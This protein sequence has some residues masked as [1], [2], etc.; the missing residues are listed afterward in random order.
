M[1]KS[2]WNPTSIAS[3]LAWAVNDIPTTHLFTVGIPRCVGY[4]SCAW[5]ACQVQ[6]EQSGYSAQRLI[7]LNK[8][9]RSASSLSHTA[10]SFWMWLVMRWLYSDTL[11]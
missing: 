6:R 11:A 10:I 2:S 1:L 5:R 4:R 8:L 9:A 3:G 7:S